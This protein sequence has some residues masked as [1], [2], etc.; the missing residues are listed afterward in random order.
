MLHLWIIALLACVV[1]HDGMPTELI[2]STNSLIPPRVGAAI[3]LGL[4][5]AIA[6][7]QHVIIFAGLS[8]VRSGRSDGAMLADRV[9]T[10][11][12]GTSVLTH[13]MGVFLLGW[14]GFVRHLIGDVILLDELVTMLPALLVFVA[15]WWSFYPIEAAFREATIISKLDTGQTLYRI[16]SRVQ[17]VVMNVRHQLLLSLLPIVMIAAWGELLPMIVGRSE[18]LLSRTIAGGLFSE[19]ARPWLEHGLSLLGAAAVFSVTPLIIRHVW[20]TV[21]LGPGEVRDRLQVM[22]ERSGVRVR[23]LLVW[24]THGSMINGAVMGL[25]APLR[26]ILLT[27]ALL[28][29]LPAKQTEA[30][31]AHEVAH[32]RYAHLPWLAGTLI[33]SAGLITAIGVLGLSSASRLIEDSRTLM[34]VF[35]LLQVG[36]QVLGLGCAVLILGHVSRRFEWQADAFAAT[37]M[38]QSTLPPSTGDT[39]VSGAPLNLV[40]PAGAHAM[41]SALESVSAL[42]HIPKARSSFR[43]GSILRRQQ[44]LL[45]IVGTPIDQLPIDRS[46]RTIKHAVLF[47]GILLIV[48]LAWI[49]IGSPEFWSADSQRAEVSR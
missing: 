49:G 25:I 18:R 45:A 5:A 33:V 7:V 39:G 41:I 23:E 11:C 31:M 12:R 34:V 4:Q 26:Y 37:Y 13:A 3:Y 42:N 15:G 1:V 28:D 21:E 46:V 6:C 44:N 14:L 47:G 30:V 17:W 8:I 40:T 20:D 32:A 38:S 22:C 27:D 19:E 29:S 48:L 24:R 43:H 10:F 35:G 9:L 2:G 36:V 16:P